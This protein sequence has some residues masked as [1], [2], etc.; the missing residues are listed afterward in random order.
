MA[1]PA[2]NDGEIAP[3]EDAG[4]GAGA[5][6]WASTVDKRTATQTTINA[7]RERDEAIC[8]MRGFETTTPARAMLRENSLRKMF[9]PRKATSRREQLLVT[10]L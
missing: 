6:S 10:D 1:H 5:Y 7:M 9:S 8:A 2:A 4:A 3:A